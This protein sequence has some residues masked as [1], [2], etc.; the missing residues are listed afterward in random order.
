MRTS[1]LEM[2]QILTE[3][4]DGLGPRLPVARGAR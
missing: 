4:A 2:R 1:Q 3:P